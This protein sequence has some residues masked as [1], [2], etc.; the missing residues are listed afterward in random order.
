[1]SVPGKAKSA[2]Q[3]RAEVLRELSP[4]HALHGIELR[5][6]ALACRLV[7]LALVALLQ[8]SVPTDV[9]ACRSERPRQVDGLSAA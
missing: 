3:L 5:V 6:I 8:S 2:E 9:P 4:G 7:E 1:M